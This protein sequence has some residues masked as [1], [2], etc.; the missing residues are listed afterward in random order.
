MGALIFFFDF[1]PLEAGAT[2][3]GP[4]VNVLRL[5]AGERLELHT[6]ERLDL[7]TGKRLELIS[8]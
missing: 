8:E 1:G 3:T 7:E 4:W 6:G 2:M 5:E